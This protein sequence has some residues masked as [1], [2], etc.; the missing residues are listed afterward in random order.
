MIE[1]HVHCAECATAI[2]TTRTTEDG[3]VEEVPTRAIGQPMVVVL[4]PGQIAVNVPP[5]PACE[6]C[7][8]QLQQAQ[9]DID[10]RLVVASASAL[11]SL[12]RASGELQR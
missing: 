10:V 12:R 7:W 8:Q 2:P 5:R 11:R 3:T 9:R 4:A 1:P 6:F